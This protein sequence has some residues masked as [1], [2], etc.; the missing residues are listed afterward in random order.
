MTTAIEEAVSVSATD[1]QLLRAYEPI[2]RYNHGELFFPTNVEGYLR[3]CDLLVG[4]SE[5]DR[6]VIVPVGELTPDRLATAVARP[7]E[8]LYLRLVQRPMAPLELARWRNRPDRQVFRAPGRLARVGLFARL[9]D[10]AFSTSLLLRG[11]VPGGTAGAAQVKYARAREGDPRLV[12][13]GR[14]VR[15][16]GWIALQYLYFYFMNDYRSTF[17]GANDHEADWEQVFVYLDDAPAGPRPVWIAAAAHDFVGDELR[18]RWDDPTLEKVDGHPV[19]YAGAGSHASYFERGEYVT[20]IP[21]PGMRGVRGLLE[22]LRAFWRESLRQPDPGD[23]AASLSAA[24]SVPFVDYAR[25]DGTSVGPG[26]DA[27]WSPVLIDD[28]TPW[29]DGYRGL[30]GLDTY[31]RFGGERAPAGPKYGRTGS[32]RMSWNDPLGFAGVDK[33]APPSRQPEELRGRIADREARLR[34]LEDAIARRSA[35]LPGLDLEARSLAADG[36]MTTL[37]K[38]RAAELATGTAE[39]EAQRRE[40]AGVAD[41]LVALRRELGRVE[42][43]DLGDPRGHLTHPHRPVP[44]ADVRYGR[45]VEFWS[46]LSVGLLLLAIVALVSLRLAPWWAA[47]GLALAGYAVLEAAFRRRLTLLTLRVELVLAM[48]SAAILVWEGLFIIVIAA[49]A[50]LALVVVLDNVRELR[51]GSSESSAPSPAATAIAP[52]SEA[53]DLD[54]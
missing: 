35:E 44:E 6:E 39:L 8:T 32:V 50:G 5:R 46:A 22:A 31:D 49:V 1:L 42:A 54:R 24:L 12:Y 17:H 20:E 13:Y 21:L 43:G 27:H 25:G 14:V 47:L 3:E 52:G 29:V 51:W 26:T 23:L 34:E 33:V 18:R 36:A 30:F 53:G 37:H 19:V 16:N 9:V 45:L 40:R 10:A 11:T 7:G 2:V 4:S 15:E 38:A 48:V 41:A 28:D